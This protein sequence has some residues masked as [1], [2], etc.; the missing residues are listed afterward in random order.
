MRIKSPNTVAAVAAL[1]LA[2]LTHSVHAAPQP[3]LANSK[4]NI[5]FILTDDLGYGD[6]GALYQ[7][8]RAAA[9]KPAFSTPHI[10][11]LA[12]SGLLLT[13]HY[14]SA[15]VCAPARASLL[16]GQSQ[17]HCAIRDN[18]FDKA[19]PEGTLTVADV[20]HNAGYRTA[21]IGKWGLAGK[22]KD[23]FPAHPMRRGFDDFF[24][25]MRHGTGHV[26]YHDAEHPLMDGTTDIG[27]K[28]ENIY[29]TDLF[30]ARAKQ[31]ITEQHQ[32]HPDQPFFL[33]L[34]YTAVH[35]ALHVPGNA[36]PAGAG[37][38][39]GLHWPLAPTPKTRN[40]WIHPDYADKPWTDAMK[41]YATMARRLDDGVG[42]ILQLLK[43]LHIDNNTLIVFTSDN[44]P[45]NEG[46]ADPRLFDSWGPFD[47]LKRDCFE[48]GVREPTL[49]AWPGH[50]PAGRTS[51]LP[52]AVY[53][54]MPTLADAASLPA[55]AQS[56]GVSILPTL[57]NSGTQQPHPPV[58]LEYFHNGKNA[59]SADVFARKH[60]TGRGQ[61][62]LVRIGDFVGVRTQIK[63]PSDPLRLY[64]VKTDPHEDHNLASDSAHAPLLK[65]MTD[66]LLTSRIPDADAARPYDDAPLPAVNPAA[67]LTPGVKVSTYAGPFPYTP[68]LSTL[69][70]T[71]TTNASAIALP[72]PLPNGPFALLFTGYLSVPADGTYTFSA[73]SDG[74]LHLWLHDAHLLSAEH[75]SQQLTASIHLKAGLHPI[76]LAYTHGKSG[77]PTLS[78]HYS[79]P[80]LPDQSVPAAALSTS[81]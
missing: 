60:V 41:R 81:P 79:G 46:G 1:L 40:S 2:C 38:H 69:S 74:G 18:Q 56:D 16:T 15:P 30:T 75:T 65:Q 67:K 10:D 71:A 7:N 49:A 17:G 57:L 33:Y 24:G 52:C 39:G 80:D 34:A 54:W 43:D 32:K 21:A 20:L 58:Y 35:N 50:I 62:Q 64:N 42:D 77:T 55:P 76:R 3:A 5:L 13:D 14:T 22:P 53:D 61:Q 4:P 44:G 68:N 36:Y 63:S 27:D 31:F 6:V 11:A 45:A 73:T 59:A 28:Y 78:L 66:L 48:G 29:S 8:A 25:Y 19:I 23:N 47:G 12:A 37:L 70:A 26:Y 9:G 72:T 51:D